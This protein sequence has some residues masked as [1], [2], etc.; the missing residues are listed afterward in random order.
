MHFEI[1]TE[2]PNWMSYW[3]KFA[4]TALPR[5]MLTYCKKQ[6]FI[7]TIF[8]H[9]YSQLLNFKFIPCILSFIKPCFNQNPRFVQNQLSIYISTKQ[10]N[11]QDYH[12]WKRSHRHNIHCYINS[13]NR[14]RYYYP[15]CNHCIKSYYPNNKVYYSVYKKFFPLFIRFYN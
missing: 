3:K 9:I 2:T 11:T 15:I 8:P 4:I 10:I 5:L 13:L 6:S 7:I 12:Y 14:P 1:N